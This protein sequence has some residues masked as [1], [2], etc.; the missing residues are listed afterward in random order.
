MQKKS[1]ALRQTLIARAFTLCFSAGA[2]GVALTNSAMAQSNASGIVFGQVAP[3]SAGAVQLKNVETNA[4][5][6]INVDS[7]GKFQATSVPA[8]RYSATL[9]KDGVAMG[10]TE[11]DVLAGQGVQAQFGEGVASVRIQGRRS[12]IDVSNTN[13]GAV[14]TAREL[15]RLPVSTDLTSVALLAPNTTRADVAFGGASFGGSG[16]S[17]NAYYINGFP[18]TNPLSNLGSSELPFGAV[19][20]AS[21]ITGGF[22]AEFGR[23]I[24]GVMNVTTKSGTN[25]WEAGVSMSTTPE[26]L[27]SKTGN[28]AYPDTGH[29]PATDGKT[30]FR[31]ELDTSSATQAAAYVGGPLIRD[32]LFGFVAFDHT[33]SNF[34]FA[35]SQDDTTLARDG[36]NDQRTRNARYLAKFDWNLSDNHRLEWTSVGDNSKVRART[37]GYDPVSGEHNDVKY[38][39]TNAKN[40][41]GAGTGKGSEINFL[42]YIGQFG[43]DL[44]ITALAGQNKAARGTTYD[45]YDINGILRS[46]NST[47]EAREPGLDAQGL[48]KNYQKYQGTTGNIG[49]PGT[50]TVKSLRLDL[51]YKLGS[52][53]IRAGMDDVKITSKNV[54]QFSAGGGNWTYKKVDDGVQFE[55]FNYS[56]G[57]EAVLADFGGLG[58][59][60]YYATLFTF[61]SVTDS[62]ARQS[63]QYIE[64]RWQ[65]TPQLLVTGGLRNE[66]YSNSVGS[67][68]KF[69][70]IKNQIAPRLSAAWDVRGDASL[71]IFGSAGRYHLQLPSQVA[72]RAAGVSSLL[73]QD[74]TYSGID[75]LGQPTGLVKINDPA[76]PDGEF[77]QVKDPRATVSKTLKP[78]YQDELT[79]GFELAYT[80]SMN[81]GLKGTYRKLGGGIDDSCDTRPIWAYAEKNGYEP[82]PLQ[83]LCYIFN[84]GDD[85]TLF[86]LDTSGKGR[87]VTIAAS[88]LGYPKAER[89]YAA[90][91]MFAEHPLRNGWYGRVNYT[92]SRSKGNMEGQTRSDTQQSDVGISAGWD[93]PEFMANSRGLL[94]N[95]RTHVLKAF[96]F[97]EI[98]REWTVGANVLVSSGRPKVCLGTNTALDR[99]IGYGPEYFYCDGKAAPRGSLGRMPVEKNVDLQLAYSPLAL[100]GLNLKVD[101]FNLFDTQTVLARRETREDGGGQIVNN[102]GE[103]RS[104]A[105]ARSVRL[106]A[107]YNHKF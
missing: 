12:R 60:G 68:V 38:S 57:R 80:P 35:N 64:D 99:Y 65:V 97:Y 49:L 20:Q 58:T 26:S 23:S 40:A 101:V 48:Y 89:R 10:T 52:H 14:F 62:G 47:P 83:T 1:Q 75:S 2:L 46:V 27:R 56:V 84:P 72:A 87:Y 73:L 43:D 29:Y 18:V 5:R 25:R 55:P 53:L 76:T 96:G 102:Y 51:E 33:V 42:K 93:F 16:A 71:K 41:T 81:I 30:H 77:G 32:R 79:M 59:R 100:K 88:E 34:A 85:V 50:D 78:N 17:E 19:A 63:A 107:A 54:G 103:T 91:D 7:A 37:F 92:L 104:T 22:G 74:F 39:E 106:S 3:G 70:D 31:R 90:I 67:G 82:D 4:A 86:S 8:G 21:V 95:D 61:S 28:I 66:Q 105:A 13:N 98:N 9:L 45:N 36:W 94:P 24:G 69:I 11:V 6:T 15:E 44:T